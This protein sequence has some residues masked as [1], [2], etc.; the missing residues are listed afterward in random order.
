MVVPSKNLFGMKEEG[1]KKVQSQAAGFREEWSL[2]ISLI[3]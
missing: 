1:K 2:S 3:S